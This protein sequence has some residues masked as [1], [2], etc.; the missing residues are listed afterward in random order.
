MQE[1]VRVVG[2]RPEHATWHAVLKEG[3]QK[4]LCLREKHRSPGV[5]DQ[6]LVGDEPLEELAF[7]ASGCCVEGQFHFEGSDRYIGAESKEGRDAADYI[8]EY[9]DRR[10]E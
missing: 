7:R 10:Q 9:L 2:D 3:R 5:G 6:R 8:A 1:R 4:V